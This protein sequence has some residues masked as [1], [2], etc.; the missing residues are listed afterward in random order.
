MKIYKEYL[1]HFGQV[2]PVFNLPT[3]FLFYLFL[4][5]F[6]SQTGMVSME[7]FDEGQ[8]SQY[9]KMQL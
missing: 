2:C 1:K 8:Y 6:S 3:K 4:L 7:S 5:R 9:E